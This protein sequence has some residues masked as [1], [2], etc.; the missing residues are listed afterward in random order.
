MLQLVSEATHCLLFKF[1]LYGL[2]NDPENFLNST[3]IKMKVIL[4]TWFLSE[5]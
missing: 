3:F 2:E 4:F 5:F 1:H